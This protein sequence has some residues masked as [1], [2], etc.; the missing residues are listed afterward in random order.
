MFGSPKG[1]PYIYNMKEEIKV[2]LETHLS[3]F[4]VPIGIEHRGVGDLVEQKVNSILLNH[5]L[6]FVTEALEARSKKSL[7]DVTWK[8]N[9]TTYWIDVKTHYIQDVTGFSMP[10]MSS[11]EKLRKLFKQPNEELLYI[12]VDYTRNDN[13]VVISEIKVFFIWELDWSVLSI[14]NL[15]RGIL[16]IK[17]NNK[18]LVFTGKGKEDWFGNLTKHAIAFH[19]K[20]IKHQQKLADIWETEHLDVH[21]HVNENEGNDGH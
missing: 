10:N 13:L 1:L 8:V 21:S 7:E 19:L 15:G 3:D 12:M 18:P 2:L 6:E 11:I 14:Q 5:P 17:D 9:N 4:T 16:Q 20:Q